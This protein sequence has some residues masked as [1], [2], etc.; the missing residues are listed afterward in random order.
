MPFFN[1][2]GPPPVTGA[3]AQQYNFTWFVFASDALRAPIAVFA[4]AVLLA[5]ISIPLGNA[6]M[7]IYQPVVV[8]FALLELAKLAYQLLTLFSVLGLSC[9][10]SAACRNR[11]PATPATAD[12]SFVLA[13][14]GSGVF[15]LVGLALTTLPGAVRRQ[16]QATEDSAA[17]VGAKSY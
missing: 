11:N 2:A 16:L 17:L 13:T 15:V 8:L 7:F 6:A 4:L 3:A 1:A 5:A 14:I 10:A 9:V 12:L